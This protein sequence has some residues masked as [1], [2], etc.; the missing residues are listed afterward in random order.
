M[1]IGGQYPEILAEI[2]ID[3]LG[4]GR[5]LYDDNVHLQSLRVYGCES[6]ETRR[7]HIGIVWPP[8]ARDLAKVSNSFQTCV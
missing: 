7:P 3:G 4:L 6:N 5:R 1:A 8:Q 2:F